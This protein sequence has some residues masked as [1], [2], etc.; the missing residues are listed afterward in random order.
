MHKRLMIRDL[1]ALCEKHGVTF[2]QDAQLRTFT[3]FDE[4]G[5]SVIAINP[6]TKRAIFRLNDL[7]LEDW[8]SLVVCA[9][10]EMER[11]YRDH[12]RSIIDRM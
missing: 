7:T 12:E 5:L 3:F 8:E 10:N 9:K 4:Y 6:R 1:K 2:Q 11:Q